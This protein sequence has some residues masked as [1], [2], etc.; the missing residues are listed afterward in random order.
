LGTDSPAIRAKFEEQKQ[1][2][3]EW[4]D[5][6]G[7]QVLFLTSV[8]SLYGYSSSKSKMVFSEIISPPPPLI[9]FGIMHF[10]KVD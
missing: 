7:N 1:P 4:T 2:V 8:A 3:F 10:T 5:Q 6:S 9:S